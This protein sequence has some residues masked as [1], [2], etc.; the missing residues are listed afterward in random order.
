[1][2]GPR[3]SANLALVAAEHD[4][5]LDEVCQRGSRLIAEHGLGNGED[6]LGRRRGGREGEDDPRCLGLRR[7][8]FVAVDLHQ[9][10]TP[11]VKAW[12]SLDL[13]LLVKTVAH[14]V[15]SRP[16]RPSEDKLRPQK[17]TNKAFFGDV[18]M[19]ACVSS[20]RWW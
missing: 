7:R 17:R 13:E 6:A 19:A 2:T 3:C 5:S 1:M 9:W 15:P 12:L 10:S 16:G 18:M 14:R 8:K 4:I 11:S 20:L